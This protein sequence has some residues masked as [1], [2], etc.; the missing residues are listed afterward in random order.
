M[1]IQNKQIQRIPS[2]ILIVGILACLGIGFLAYGIFAHKSAVTQPIAS[3]E[4]SSNADVVKEG[5][6]ETAVPVEAIKT[7]TVPADEPRVLRIDSLSLNAKVR[8]M[9]IN[10]VGAIQAPVNI[11]DGGWYSGSSKPGTPG[12][13]FIDG[14]ASGATRKGLFAYIDT[15]KNGTTISLERG[16]GQLF[17]YKVVHV[18]TLPKES[19]DMY[20]VLHTY[21][22]VDE[23]LNLMTCTGTWLPNEKTYDKRAIVYAERV[24]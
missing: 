6:D 13:V 22:D 7:Y 16:D 24:S 20:K 17:N 23:G 1:K 18:E 15:L 11:Y 9:A 14:H 21:G 5:S 8:P 3:G 4:G 19:V 10:S 2:F 12:A